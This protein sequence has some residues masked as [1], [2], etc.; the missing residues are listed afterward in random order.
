MG[1]HSLNKKIPATK[2]KLL[3][4]RRGRGNLSNCKDAGRKT[5]KICN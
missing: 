3:T 4:D 1:Q 5:R 2:N